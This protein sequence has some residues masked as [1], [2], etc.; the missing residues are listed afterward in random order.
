MASATPPTAAEREEPARLDLLL[1]STGE[2]IYGIDTTGACTF[3]NQAG[4]RLIGWRPD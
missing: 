3:I 4:A 1:E 2:G